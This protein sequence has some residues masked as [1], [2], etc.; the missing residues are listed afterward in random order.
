[1]IRQ[2]AAVGGE[3]PSRSERPKSAST[4]GEAREESTLAIAKTRPPAQ[5]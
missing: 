2:K 5:R 4:R 3:D 1:M